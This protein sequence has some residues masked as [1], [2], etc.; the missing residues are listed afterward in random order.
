M[1]AVLKACGMKSQTNMVKTLKICK[2]IKAKYSSYRDPEPQ[3]LL[4]ERYKEVLKQN[5]SQNKSLYDMHSDFISVCDEAPVCSMCLA[6]I[7]NEG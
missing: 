7:A 5:I 1:V 2:D 3:G 6:P 4:P